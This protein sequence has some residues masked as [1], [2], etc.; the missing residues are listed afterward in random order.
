MVATET[1]SVAIRAVFYVQFFGFP[2]TAN[3][4]NNDG[5][6]V[7]AT[8]SEGRRNFDRLE[9][10]ACESGAGNEKLP[11]DVCYPL[12]G[13]LHPKPRISRR[14]SKFVC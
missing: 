11:D 1:D 13:C 9:P 10:H 2:A 6:H 8:F 5:L 4:T 3:V 14:R 12:A 7:T